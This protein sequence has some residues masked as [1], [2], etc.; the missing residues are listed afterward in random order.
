MKVSHICPRQD[1]SSQVKDKATEGKKRTSK[2]WEVRRVISVAFLA[3]SV[4]RAALN[5]A[6]VGSRPTGGVLF[7]FCQNRKVS[8]KGKQSEK[9]KS[10]KDASAWD[11]TKDLSVNSRSLCLL[12]H[13]SFLISEPV[14]GTSIRR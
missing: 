4:E 3:Q 2:K 8:Q 14:K 9:K 6:V 5:R 10:K 11:R 13:G 12:S 7:V 1:K